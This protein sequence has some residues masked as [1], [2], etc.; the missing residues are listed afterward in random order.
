M[1]LSLRFC[2]LAH[3]SFSICRSENCFEQKYF[4]HNTLYRKAY[5]ILANQTKESELA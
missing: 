2:F 4:M 5:G 3:S 1:K